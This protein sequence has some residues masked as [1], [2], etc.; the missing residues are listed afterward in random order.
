MVFAVDNEYFFLHNLLKKQLL[1]YFFVQFGFYQIN[2]DK[3]KRKT[4]GGEGCDIVIKTFKW[5]CAL[6]NKVINL[7]SASLS[8]WSIIF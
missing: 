2:L 6:I 7:S 8:T 4:F 3:M 1:N 5:H